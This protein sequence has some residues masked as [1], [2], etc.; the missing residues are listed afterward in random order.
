MFKDKPDFDDP[1]IDELED[2]TEKAINSKIKTLESQKFKLK[3]SMRK[4]KEETK[5]LQK[6][7]E[8]LAGFIKHAK[9]HLIQVKL[10]LQS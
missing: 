4:S 5:K 3:E 8:K 10:Q 6:N 2:Q 7:K 9:M 1:Y